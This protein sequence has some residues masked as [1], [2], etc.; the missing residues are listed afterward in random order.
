MFVQG[1][2]VYGGRRVVFL[3][4]TLKI[5]FTYSVASTTLTVPGGF[6]LLFAVCTGDTAVF[7]L[8][9]AYA[10]SIDPPPDKGEV[11]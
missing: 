2:L 3:D 7:D 8:I 10:S 4:Y 11:Y 1:K 6:P 9:L 5:Y